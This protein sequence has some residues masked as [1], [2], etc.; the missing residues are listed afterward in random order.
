MK[1]SNLKVIGI[2]AAML[3]TLLFFS[4]LFFAMQ[5]PLVHVIRLTPGEDLRVA[6]Q[7]YVDVKG[8]HAASIVSAVGSLTETQIR[9]ANMEESSSMKGHFEIVSLSGIVSAKHTHLHI[10]VSDST[11]KTIGGHLSNGNK[12]YTTAEIVLMEYPQYLFSRELCPL[13]GYQELS[14]KLKK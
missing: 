8:I 11:G 7:S 1:P 12:I 2:L 10:A 3:A 14:I 4:I 13:S 9:Y 6:L 5:R